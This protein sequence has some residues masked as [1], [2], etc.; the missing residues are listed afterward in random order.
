MCV[1]INVWHWQSTPR[2]NKHRNFMIPKAHHFL[3][4]L[5]LVTFRFSSRFRSFPV[6]VM[7]SAARVYRLLFHLMA[8]FRHNLLRQTY[9]WPADL[10]RIN[11]AWKSV[12]TP[13]AL[14]FPTFFDS[15]FFCAHER[16]TRARTPRRGQIVVQFLRVK[17]FLRHFTI[18]LSTEQGMA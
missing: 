10:R 4:I 13:S 16:L 6:Y 14:A 11:S 2:R 1:V 8:H 7:S 18:W 15:S 5:S 17:F 9:M 12:H 3:A